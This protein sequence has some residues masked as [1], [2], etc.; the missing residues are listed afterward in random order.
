MPKFTNKGLMAYARCMCDYNTPY[1]Y[2]VKGFICSEALYKQKKAQYP[3]QYP[4]VKWTEES[5]RKQ[6]G[7][8]G[9]DCSGLPEGYL[10]SPCIDANGICTDP[11]KP[12]VYNSK[13]DWSANTMIERCKEKGDIST[14]PEIEGLVLWKEGHVA[15]YD[16]KDSNGVRWCI[17]AKGHAFG[18]VRSKVSER[19]F[20]KWGKLPE[21]EYITDEPQPSPSPIEVGI[22]LPT[23]QKGDKNDQ[24]TLL[25]LLLNDLGFRDQNG[26]LLVID[27]S[28]GGKTIYALNAFKKSVKMQADSICDEATWSAILHKRFKEYPKK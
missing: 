16:G 22:S 10:M 1:W 15:L 6:F 2:G 11:M 18:T 21:V 19:G 5:F 9:H 12:S 24:V 28:A 17:E 25:Q 3:S 14:M 26:D 4:P 7:K 20:K 27:G 23:I 8:K 13:Y